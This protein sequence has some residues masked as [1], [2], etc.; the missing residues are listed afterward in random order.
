MLALKLPQASNFAAPVDNL[1]DFI[2][3]IS[4]IS[5]I[6]TVVAMLYFMWRYSQ[7]KAD[8]KKTAYI[9]GHTGLELAVSVVLLVLVMIIF[10]WGWVDYAKM[11]H[12]PEDAL[13]INVIGKQWSWDIEYPNGRKLLNK[14][15]IP[16]GK[17]IKLIMGSADVLHSFYIPSFRVKQDLVPKR[18]TKLWFTGI[19]PGDFPV[20]CAEF[21]GTSHSAMLATVTVL[22]A[23]EYERWQKTWELETRLGIT[24]HA[25]STDKSA[26]LASNLSPVAKGKH[27]FKVKNCITCHK[28]SAERLVGPGFAGLFGSERK[29]VD[30]STI[31]ADENYLRESM[32]DPNLKVLEGYAPM[33]PTYQGQLTDE[34]VH[35]LVAFIKSL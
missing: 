29:F 28:T 10:A 12:A 13:E 35:N 21:C 19:M 1:Y 33:M 31:K 25:D 27:L 3:W 15:V 6:A 11:R 18:F 24:E 9:E 4:V 5:F 17:P 16:K 23:S 7:K 2:M 22:E 26:L 30:G 14:L 34:E 8:P 32:M 20:Y